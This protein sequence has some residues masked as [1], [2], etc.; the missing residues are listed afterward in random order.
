MCSEFP[1]YIEIKKLISLCP[2]AFNILD[3]EKGETERMRERERERE[4]E[5][6]GRK[7]RTRKMGEGK[8]REKR[9][10]D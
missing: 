7:K 5:R 10:N 8:V 9:E 3:Y 1:V 6:G 4:A 2:E